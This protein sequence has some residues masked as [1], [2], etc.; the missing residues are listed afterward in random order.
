MKLLDRKRS[1]GE[2]VLGVLSLYMALHVWLRAREADRN[3]TLWIAVYRGSIGPATPT[4]G[5]IIAILSLLFALVLFAIFI[6]SRRA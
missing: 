3:H 2:V 6:F 1:W 5:Y 4:Q